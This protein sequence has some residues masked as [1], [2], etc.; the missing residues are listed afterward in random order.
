MY[1]VFLNTFREIIRSR[2][3]VIVSFFAVILFAGIIFL[4]ILSLGQSEFIVPDFGL[5]FIEMSSL[6]LILFMGNRLL[7]REFEEKTI[8]LTLSRPIER[9]KIILGKFLGFEAVMTI[10]VSALTIILIILM[11]AY[12][13]AITPIFF[14]AIF[15]IFLKL[16]IL[17]ALILFFSIFLS[18]SVA[19]FLILAVYIIAHSGYALLEFAQHQ[20]NEMMLWVGRA[21]L[22]FFPNFQAINYKNFIHSSEMI[23]NTPLNIAISIS[24]AL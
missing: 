18:S 2:F 20:A 15:G 23:I 11:M 8:Y 14:L 3:F 7:S 17:V 24:I 6:L 16:T 21:I 12:K 1:S 4:E 13:V 5:S 10:F 9:G 19:T 22:F